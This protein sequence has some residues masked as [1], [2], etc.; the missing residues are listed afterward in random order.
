MS[1]RR[2][3]RAI[4]YPENVS[5]ETLRNWFFLWVG[6]AII[7]LSTAFGTAV[8]WK[9]SGLDWGG[10]LLLVINCL[11][12][13]ATGVFAAY[14]F[15]F[16]YQG[17]QR[18]QLEELRHTAQPDLLVSVLSDLAY[19][20]GIYC[21]DHKMVAT[22]EPHPETKQYLLCRIKHDY[23]KSRILS[24]FRA[25]VFRIPHDTHLSDDHF[26]D[27]AQEAMSSEFVWYNDERDF[28]AVPNDLDYDVQ[29]LVVEQ[30]KFTLRKATYK[31][32]MV[33][34]CNLPAFEENL[35]HITFEFTFPMELE[36]VLSLTAEYPS[37]RGCIT[38]DFSRFRNELD[39]VALPKIGIERSPIE[40]HRKEDGVY[41][42]QYGDWALPKDGCAFAW[43]TKKKT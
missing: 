12:Q 41:Q 26:P 13:L 40:L 34:W 30:Q 14:V 11:F 25:T 8:H 35:K 17:R 28:P 18:S 21:E 42:Y 3:F 16:Y 6:F 33:F 39:V 15:A 2:D 9:L 4:F 31:D 38:F 43:W 37:H 29:H 7:L 23:K 22:L 27:I 19:Y 36:S 20:R 10:L 24:Q 1:P 5:K 32:R